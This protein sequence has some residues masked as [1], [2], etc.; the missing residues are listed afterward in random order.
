MSPLFRRAAFVFSALVG[1]A[2]A[3]A[4]STDLPVRIK[5]IGRRTSSVTVS[6]E[7]MTS[8]SLD[9]WHSSR[10]YQTT[11]TLT[12]PGNGEP[13]LIVS[14]YE[15]IGMQDKQVLKLVDEGADGTLD[16]VLVVRAPTITAANARLNSGAVETAKPDASMLA[17]YARLVSDL[18]AQTN[19]VHLAAVRH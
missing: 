15:S 18:R 14:I 2:H 8:Y 11:L 10:G 1:C 13:T 12:E 3:V 9:T 16:Y 4:P 6:G 7:T 19:D 5:A 17:T